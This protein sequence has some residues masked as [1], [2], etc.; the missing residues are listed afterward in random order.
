MNLSNKH[1]ELIENSD[2]HASA[3]TI[4]K[5]SEHAEP[6]VG[7]YIGPNTVHGHVIVAGRREE[8]RSRHRRDRKE[9]KES[10][11]GH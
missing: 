9:Q 5:F 10:G 2:G 1:F 7:T 8:N 6:F 3:R 4:M 11:V